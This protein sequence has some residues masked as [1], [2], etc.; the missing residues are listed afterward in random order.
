MKSNYDKNPSIRVSENDGECISGWE[1]IA[2]SLNERIDQEASSVIAIE[3]Y[4]GVDDDEVI[5]ALEQLLPAHQFYSTSKAFKEVSAIEKMVYPFVTDDRVF[6]YMT[7]LKMEDFL[8]KDRFTQLKKQTQKEDKVLKIVYGPAA[9]LVSDPDLVIYIDMARWEIQQRMRDKEVNNLGV[10]NK[11]AEAALLYK[12]SYFVDWRVL[13]QHKLSLFDKVDYF[14]DG[15]KKSNPKM[16]TGDSLNAGLK[17]ANSQ[18]FR[19]VPFFDPGVWGGQWLKEVVDLDRSAINYAWGFDCVPEENSI[20]LAYGSE[21]FETPAVNLVLREP[22]DLLGQEVYNKFGAEFPIRFDFLDTMDGG[23][24]SLQ[25]HPDKKY[26]KEKFGMTYTQDESY[27]I[28]D[29]KEGAHVYLGLSE[30]IEPEKMVSELKDA[31][32]NGSTFEAE[33]HVAKWPVKKHDHVLIPAGTVHCSGK[34]SM[35]LEISA[36]PY[37]FT[38]KLYDWGRL[39]MDNKPRPINIGHG[40]KVIQWDR[41]R[42]WTGENLVNNIEKVEEGDSWVEER[43]GLYETNFIETRRHWFTGKVTHTTG[44]GVNV[45]NLVEGSEV[46][47]E[48]PTDSFPPFIVHYAETFI[49]PA[50]VGEYTIRPH[51][52]SEGQKCGTVKAY[53]RN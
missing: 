26:I 49:I 27:Y 11:D 33:K 31:Q 17:K 20:L 8:D 44:G 13:D 28:L 15:N 53:V 25:V 52:E 22:K 38:F 43:T 14:I 35:V 6:G 40:E 34:D 4:Q 29:A 46:I 1:N 48:S 39:G 7:D 51:G 3:T 47:V 19:V 42:D 21:V 12:Q 5:K 30:D 50:A 18:P 24:L 10:E 45:L 9:T 2:K 41:T 37:I 23:N 16:I 32:E 36:T